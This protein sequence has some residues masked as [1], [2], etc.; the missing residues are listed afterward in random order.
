[1]S[2]Y[3]DP[4]ERDNPKSATWADDLEDRADAREVGK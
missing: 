1:M 4:Y 2:N 3:G